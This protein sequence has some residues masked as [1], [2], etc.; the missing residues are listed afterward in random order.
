MPFV[1]DAWIR[2]SV[3]AQSWIGGVKKAENSIKALSARVKVAAAVV[4]N[5]GEKSRKAFVASTAALTGL[6]VISSKFEQSMARVQALTDATAEEFTNL[7]AVAME[8]GRTTI[9]SASQAAEAMSFFALAG[10]EANKIMEALPHALNLAAAGQI[11]LASASDITAKI[12]AGMGL[13]ADELEH[14]VDVL[15]KG[16]TSANTT[17]LQLGDAMKFVGPIGRITG[18]SIEE[19]TSAIQVMS[20]AGIQGG[21]AGT[22]LRNILTRLTGSTPAVR[23]VL[24]ELGVTIADSTGKM[25]P[26]ADIVDDL[27]FRMK[28]LNEVEKTS[29]IMMLFGQ[30]AGPAMATM[31]EEG[32]EALRRYEEAL[33]DSGGTAEK[34]AKIQM[35]TFRGSLIKLKSAAEGAA[36]GIGTK[37]QP[38]LRGVVNVLYDVVTWFNNSNGTLQVVTATVVGTSVAFLGLAVSM[39]VA[40]SVMVKAVIPAYIAGIAVMKTFL[41]AIGPLGWIVLALT[42]LATL[43]LT[44]AY[45]H[46][47]LNKEIKKIGNTLDETTK[48]WKEYADELKKTEQGTRIFI[49]VLKAQA[50]VAEGM[51]LMAVS[52][53]GSA[54]EVVAALTYLKQNVTSSLE[55]NRA[56]LLDYARIQIQLGKEAER[57]LLRQRDIVVQAAK[58]AERASKEKLAVVK[59][60]AE[61]E[62]KLLM[63]AERNR[64]GDLDFELQEL[65]Y[66][67]KEKQ[68][69]F[70]GDLIMERTLVEI[71]SSRKKEIELKYADETVQG[72]K[73]LR[74]EALDYR[75]GQFDAERARLVLWHAEQKRLYADHK[76]GLD[77][78]DEI[79]EGRRLEIL[80]REEQAAIKTAKKIAKEA[81]DAIK[82][83]LVDVLVSIADGTKTVSESFRDMLRSISHQLLEMAAKKLVEKALGGG[84]PALGGGGGLAGILSGLFGAPVQL[85]EGG[86]ITRPT[87]AILGEGGKPEAVIPLDKM[88]GMGTTV[89]LNISAIDAKGVAAFFAKNKDLV[90]NS[91][92]GAIQGNNPIRRRGQ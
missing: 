64:M 19:L 24:D 36:I 74:D 23:R 47:E 18:K 5:F 69:L 41:L 46:R 86:I 65:K 12:M 40:S 35:A 66:W 34:I 33:Q 26:L 68:E 91:V 78:L 88:S 39:G 42:A 72:I 20:N 2:L 31:L 89:N 85:S 17:L 53:H 56:N 7:S 90:A 60:S 16:F 21:M 29:K 61:E 28:G 37:L 49:N 4:Q 8:L 83:N 43:L 62:K 73:D 76:E 70:E 63:E 30:R 71:Y 57:R 80:E 82:L 59:F 1:G 44:V 52:A 22:S 79:Y 9:F 58:D 84:D 38:A 6:V 51:R 3:K 48:L 15:A 11:D 92:S 10:F 54:K 27:N 67:Y 25:L 50:D 45:R 14:A 75:L 81:G 77:L 32:G 13:S 87:R 55:H